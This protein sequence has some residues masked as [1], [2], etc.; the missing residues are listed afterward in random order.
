MKK[1]VFFVVTLGIVLALGMVLTGC[2][3]KP[4]DGECYLDNSFHL[5]TGNYRYCSESS[6][7]VSKSI[8]ERGVGTPA[9]CDC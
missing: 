2:E 9:K 6:C 7:G 4:C 8:Q 5:Q 1:K 3:A